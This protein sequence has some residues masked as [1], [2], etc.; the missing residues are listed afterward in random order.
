MPSKK[1]LMTG[2]MATITSI[3]ILLGATYDAPQDFMSNNNSDDDRKNV[4]KVAVEEVKKEKKVSFIERI[5]IGL[6]TLVGIPLWA[7]G[8]LII[9]IFG[10]FVLPPILNFFS[11]FIITLGIIVLVF[12]IAIKALF[13][14]VPLKKLLNKRS[15]IILVVGA[16]LLTAIDA[17]MPLFIDNYKSYKFLLYFCIGL[18]VIVIL[19][20]PYLKKKA[21]DLRKPQVIFE[22]V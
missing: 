16:L 13:P 5:P 18:I 11:S 20:I 12:I 9:N 7:L 8:S 22:E 4:L 3:G 15:F 14:N 10:T 2:L 1:K 21:S 19:L 6:R 17:I